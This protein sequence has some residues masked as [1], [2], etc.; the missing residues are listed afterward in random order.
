MFGSFTIDVAG[1][2]GTAQRGAERK[3]NSLF[4]SWAPADKPEIVVVS[5]I[6]SGGHGGVAAALASLRFY[7]SYFHVP[8]PN[9]GVIQDPST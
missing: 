3:D 9:L 7:S 2:T 4:V 6:E 8:M 1:K 5:V